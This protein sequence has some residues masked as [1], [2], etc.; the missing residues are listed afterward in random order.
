MNALKKPDPVF[1][2]S[3]R[4]LLHQYQLE[5]SAVVQ[6]I[7]HDRLTI[8]DVEA[9]KAF[10][11]KNEKHNHNLTTEPD[12][13][14]DES[15]EKESVIDEGQMRRE[16]SRVERRIPMSRMRLKIAER[17]VQAQHT[18]AM[19]TTFNEINMQPIMNLRAHYKEEFE[20]KHKV[21]LGFMSFFIKAS[22]YALE[23]FP[24]LN[25]SIDGTDIIYHDYSDV[26]I[27]VSSE[28]GLVVPVIR[29]AHQYSLAEL[30]KEVLYLSDKAKKS[31]LT[32]DDLTGGTFTITNG[33]VFGSLLSTPI[34][35]PPQTA[36]LGMHKIEERPIVIDHEVVIRPMMYVALSYDHRLIDGA[37]AVQFL[38][39]IKNILQE[40]ERLLLDL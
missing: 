3:V 24:V 32:L 17:L 33:G 28:R 9:Y 12:K 22:C 5:G 11:G 6:F 2:P 14:N 15:H 34:I 37:D 4:K 18:A 21:K 16:Q 27:A 7:G 39:S 25:A 20:K 30:E 29:N 8:E 13:I 1:I 19:L 35:N 40:P 10:Q 31:T 23:H 36:I 38:V 26:S